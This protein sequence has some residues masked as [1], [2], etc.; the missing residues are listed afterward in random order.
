MEYTKILNALN[1]ASTFDLYRLQIAIAREIDNPQRIIKIKKSLRLGMETS[2]FCPEKNALIQVKI[3]ALKRTRVLVEEINNPQKGLGTIPYCMLNISNADTNIYAN[4]QKLTA[5]NLSV[6]E[7]VG[8]N[9]NGNDIIG[10]IERL[11]QKTVSLT[12]T[13]GAKWRVAYANLYR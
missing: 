9:H 5:N 10:M 7:I 13:T 8:F 6:D 1:E 3:M 12:T 2:Y 11:N 4:N